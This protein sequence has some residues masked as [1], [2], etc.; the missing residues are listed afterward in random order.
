MVSLRQL[1]YLVAVADHGSFTRAAEQLHVTQPALSHQM[2]ILERLS[3][4]PLV[5]RLPRSVRLTPAGRAMLPHARAALAD[6]YRARCAA[7]QVSGL[8]Q[9]EL[10]LAAVYSVGLGVLP[11]VLRRWR[12]RHHDV[13]ISLSE[14]RHTEELVATMTEGGADLAVGPSPRRWSGPVWMLGDEEFVVV[15]PPDD[16]AGADGARRVDL[17]ELADRTW[18]HYASGNGLAEVVDQACG[19]AGFRPAAA[20]RTEQTAAAPVLASAGLGPALVPANMVPPAFDGLVLRPDPPV[21]RSLTAYTRPD[22]DPLTEA[23]VEMLI[24]TACVLPETLRDRLG[25]DNGFG[26][27]GSPGRPLEAVT[28]RDPSPPT[29]TR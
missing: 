2:R 22:P 20:V 15:L 19:E 11:P 1:E 18:V 13:Q 26:H 29:A 3:G 10:R 28:P 14:H 9:G 24:E 25:L 5:E 23:F 8:D 12:Q 6:A 4:G 27:L 21:R 16:P 17:A 7:R